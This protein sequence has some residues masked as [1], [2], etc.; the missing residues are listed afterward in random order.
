MRGLNSLR[1]G[2]R[3]L[4]RTCGAVR[5]EGQVR[6]G[7]QGYTLIEVLVVLG[8]VALLMGLVGPRVISYLGDSKIKT[9]R[10]QIDGFA[11]ALDLYHLDNGRYPTSSEGLQAL[12]QKP[13]AAPAWNGPY[14]R[15]GAV[16]L[17]PWGR[18]YTYVF[19]GQHGEYDIVSLG[20]NGREGDP[21]ANI[22]SW[23]R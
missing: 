16:P 8:I 4:Q 17:D 15:T 21:A 6:K 3:G 22:T 7:E 12:V 18:P 20:P 19:P 5:D 10:L 23:K 2:F 1:V 9:T 11:A 13:E 14:L